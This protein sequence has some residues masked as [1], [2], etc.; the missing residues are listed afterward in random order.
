M[1]SS[2]PNLLYCFTG[3]SD[4][5][6]GLVIKGLLIFCCLLCCLAAVDLVEIDGCGLEPAAEV[7]GTDEHEDDDE[8][9]AGTSE[10]AEAAAVVVCEPVVAVVVLTISLSFNIVGLLAIS[11]QV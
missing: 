6:D 7:E 10:D 1:S 5:L 9:G 2:G 8:C 4:P 11:G 3:S